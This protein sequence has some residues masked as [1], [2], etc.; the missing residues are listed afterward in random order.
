[1]PID[2][3]SKRVVSVYSPPPP[4]PPQKKEINFHVICKS[5]TPLNFG[6]LHVCPLPS[7]QA[8]KI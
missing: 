1:M 5:P 4:P 6:T 2:F 7:T 8:K 3:V